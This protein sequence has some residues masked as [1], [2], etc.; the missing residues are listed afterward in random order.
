MGLEFL[1]D[2]RMNTGRIMMVAVFFWLMTL[3]TSTALASGGHSHAH[4]PGVMQDMPMNSHSSPQAV[5]PFEKATGKKHIHCD[6]LRHSPQLPCPHH[7]IPAEDDEPSSLANDC[8]GG[9]A[10]STLHKD[11]RSPFVAGRVLFTSPAAPHDVKLA[12]KLFGPSA[13][14]SVLTPPP[15]F[16]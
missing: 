16:S 8:G 11:S 6:L 10:G 1:Y 3:A 7:K 12:P 15:E 9:P 4:N 5:S 14:P 13:T 2:R